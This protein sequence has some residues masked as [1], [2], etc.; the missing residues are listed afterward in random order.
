M[1]GV[2]LL[3]GVGPG[4]ALT[5]RRNG[6]LGSLCAALDGATS[7]NR[8]VES[9]CLFLADSDMV[10]VIAV[11]VLGLLMLRT[12]KREE[13]RPTRIAPSQGVLTMAR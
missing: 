6:V 7:I 13:G 4:P 1:V 11:S 12:A 5:A 10:V 9:R 3:P 8:S 2:F